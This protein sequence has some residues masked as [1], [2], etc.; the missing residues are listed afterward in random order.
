MQ[1]ASYQFPLEQKIPERPG[2]R[3]NRGFGRVQGFLIVLII[4]DE[5]FDPLQRRLSF[6]QREICR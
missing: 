2:S 3:W 6:T 4:V 5:D 1:K